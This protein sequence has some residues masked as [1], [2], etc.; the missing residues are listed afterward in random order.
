MKSN[1]TII[2]GIDPGTRVTGYGLI[3]TNGSHYRAIDY[4]CIRPP[5]SLALSDRYLIIYQSLLQILDNYLPHVLVVESQYVDKN[6]RSAL[7]LGGARC[8][9]ILAAKIRSLKV[10]EYSP[11]KAK[12]ATVGWGKASKSQVQQMTKSLLN[13]KELPQPQDAADA[14]SLAICHALN[15]HS[16][17]N[18]QKEI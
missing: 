15:L 3:A 8:L 13:L 11:T 18:L 14:L 10:Y 6:P 4:G 2:I 5:P 16:K 9:A 1:E 17:C 12:I 7:T